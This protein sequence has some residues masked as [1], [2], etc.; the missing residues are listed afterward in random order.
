MYEELLIEK[1]T[2][3]FRVFSRHFPQIG[4]VREEVAAMWASSERD[5]EEET[6]LEGR[7]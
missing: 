4:E 3:A 1:N 6:V 5:G 7:C 2:G